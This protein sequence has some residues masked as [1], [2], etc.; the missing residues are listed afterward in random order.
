MSLFV[1]LPPGTKIADHLS[2]TVDRA[3]LRKAGYERRLAECR[4]LRRAVAAAD[5]A[6][7]GGIDEVPVRTA[8]GEV[9]LNQ[10]AQ[11]RR[12]TNTATYLLVY[13]SPRRALV[14]RLRSWLCQTW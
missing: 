6:V 3:Q 5:A 12:V 7:N 4:K 11:S 8:K 1:T 14:P 13:N 10:V 9:E 2:L